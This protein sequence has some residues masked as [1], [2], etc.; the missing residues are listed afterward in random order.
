MTT[1][2][3]TTTG[4]TTWCGRGHHCGLGEHRS[5][6]A[7]WRTRYGSL[8]ASLVQRSHARTAYLELRI[9]V[10]IRADEPTT[11]SQA[12]AIAAGIHAAITAATATPVTG[13]GPS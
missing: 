11:R 5:T 9:S 1:T 13:K 8:I 4:H 6:P 7:R 2:Q 12:V 10:A 3:M